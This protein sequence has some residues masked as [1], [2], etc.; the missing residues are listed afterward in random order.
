[1]PLAGAK[2]NFPFRFQILMHDNINSAAGQK[3]KIARRFE[4]K[5]KELFLIV[6]WE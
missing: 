4:M 5:F 1:M 6:Y 2:Y 3:K